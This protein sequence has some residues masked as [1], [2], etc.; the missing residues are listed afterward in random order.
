MRFVRQPDFDVAAARAQRRRA[1]ERAEAVAGQIPARGIRRLD[2]HAE[3]F[4]ERPRHREQRA[5]FFVREVRATPDRS[6]PDGH[7]RSARAPAARR[8]SGVAGIA[9][10]GA[11]H[12]R[13]SR[14][15]SAAGLHWW[16][17]RGGRGSVAPVAPVAPVDNA[18]NWRAIHRS[19]GSV[20]WKSSPITRST[21]VRARDQ[22]VEGGAADV[23]E[24]VAALG[25]GRQRE[26][27]QKMEAVGVHD[28]AHCRA[29]RAAIS[30]G[31]A[32][33]GRGR[34]RRGGREAAGGRR[35]HLRWGGRRAAGGQRE[36]LRRGG[37]VR[38]RRRALCGEG[39]E[40]A[41]RRTAGTRQ[42]RQRV[43]AATRQLRQPVNRAH[44][45][46]AA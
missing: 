33:G 38:D 4:D 32:D 3:F 46:T 29:K 15:S 27:K 43:H 18:P 5:G 19:C 1:G 13:A 11:Q 37:L 24:A 26:R 42:L 6:A 41:R 22:P 30:I 8:P 20:R 2:S 25:C 21:S 28:A 9:A 36:P 23:V 7:A 44:A 35:E 14:A 31:A 45:S 16:R 34:W 40:R 10:V 17:R 12:V 39:G